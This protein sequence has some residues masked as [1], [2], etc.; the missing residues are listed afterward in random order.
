M[1]INK[2]RKNGRSERIDLQQLIAAKDER[3]LQRRTDS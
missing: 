1:T 2:K 3:G